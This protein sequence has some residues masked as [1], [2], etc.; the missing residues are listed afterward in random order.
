MTA[1]D[2]R[3][4]LKFR[5]TGCGNCCR[6]TIVCLTDADIRRIIEGTGKSPL[7]FVRFYNHDHIAM[8]EDDPLWV[9]LGKKKL[10]M[11]L[12]ST[13]DRCVF[14]ENTT[15]RCTIYEHRPV[16]CRDHPFNVTLSDSGAVEKISLSRIVKCPHDW[17]GNIHRSELRRINNWNE[18]QQKAYV[19]KIKAWN[20]LNATRK[21]GPAF[22]RFLGFDV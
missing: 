6:N 14:L 11:G 12:R 17:D 22:L 13:H 19:E 8:S 9:K 5:C 4:Y 7:E 16:T 3:R 18:Q 2:W 20:K 15:N 1:P 10:V 21:T